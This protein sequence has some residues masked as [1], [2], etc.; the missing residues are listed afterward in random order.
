MSWRASGYVKELAQCPDGA[1]L[2]R[3]QKLLALIL[4]DY[5]NT[6][7]CR[8]WP[9]IPTLVQEA[10]CSR[11]TVIRDLNHLEAHGLIRQIHPERQ[12]RGQ[13]C[14]YIFV[15]LD[16]GKGFHG[17]TLSS[18]KRVSEGSHGEQKRVS[19]G[20][21]PEQRNKEELRTKSNEEEN[22]HACGELKIWKRGR[23]QEGRNGTH[24]GAREPDFIPPLERKRRELG[25]KPEPPLIAQEVAG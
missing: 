2:G 21:H 23:H 22:H 25:P 7:H 15:E 6:A 18:N 10:L 4:A 13:R 11:A 9:S 12:G 5:H 19:E 17:D 14:E 16:E 1:P 3:G 8:A 24:R 20:A